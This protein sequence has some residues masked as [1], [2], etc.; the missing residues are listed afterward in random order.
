M[1]WF[2]EPEESCFFEQPNSLSMIV[3]KASRVHR[4]SPVRTRFILHLWVDC[5]GEQS[6]SVCLR[7]SPW[8]T[9]LTGRGFYRPQSFKEIIVVSHVKSSDKKLLA[10]WLLTSGEA[11]SVV[12]VSEVMD[13]RRG[14]FLRA[15]HSGHSDG[16]DLASRSLRRSQRNRHTLSADGMAP[17]NLRRIHGAFSEQ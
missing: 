5:M 7:H 17:P 1:D 13:G 14:R 11:R 12:H 2:S 3:L 8:W 4:Y 15:P 16:T 6:F 10:V 9:H